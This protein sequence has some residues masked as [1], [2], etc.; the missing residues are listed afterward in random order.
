MEKK[1]A[2]TGV[3]TTEAHGQK[4][5]TAEAGHSPVKERENQNLTRPI[6]KGPSLRLCG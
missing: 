2:F 3:S 4:I 6:L 5:L 1:K